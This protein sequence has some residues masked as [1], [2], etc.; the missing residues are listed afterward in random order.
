MGKEGAGAVTAQGLDGG[1]VECK[2]PPAPMGMGLN[3]RK[4]VLATSH[5]QRRSA[6][7]AAWREERKAVL[8]ASKPSEKFRG[9]CQ[10]MRGASK[11]DIFWLFNYEHLLTLMRSFDIKEHSVF[12][13]E[14]VAW[15]IVWVLA[16]YHPKHQWRSRQL[17]TLQFLAN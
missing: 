5:Q 9:L 10:L 1:D 13:D 11:S 4:V 15:P 2:I 14:D 6:R 3:S 17:P 12:V 16:R 8:R 7:R